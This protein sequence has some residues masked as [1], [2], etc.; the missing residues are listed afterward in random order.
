MIHM[1][2]MIHTRKIVGHMFGT[3]VEKHTGVGHIFGANSWANVGIHK[4]MFHTFCAIF[5]EPQCNTVKKV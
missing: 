4:Y 3:N 2:H 1:I 5:P